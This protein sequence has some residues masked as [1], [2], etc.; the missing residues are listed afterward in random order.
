MQLILLRDEAVEDFAGLVVGGFWVGV[1]TGKPGSAYSIVA[2][3]FVTG[4]YRIKHFCVDHLTLIVHCDDYS[5]VSAAVAFICWNLQV[6]RL[7]AVECI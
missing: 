1:E 2:K 3:A 5:D 7:S 6:A 4:R